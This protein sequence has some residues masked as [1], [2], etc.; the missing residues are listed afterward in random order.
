MTY[1]GFT[2]ALLERMD[3]TSVDLFGVIKIAIERPVRLNLPSLTV[4]LMEKG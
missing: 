3:A 4:S 1:D 2:L